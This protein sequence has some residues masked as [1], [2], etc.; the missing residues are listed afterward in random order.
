MR[1]I[2]FLDFDGVLHADG[3]AQLSRLALFEAR[4]RLMPALEIVISSSWREHYS[5][6]S[7]R[8]FFHPDLRHRIIGLTPLL[9]CRYAPSGRQLEIEAYLHAECLNES[10]CRWLALDDMAEMFQGDCKYLLLVDSTQGFCDSV[11]SR[12]ECW[13]RDSSD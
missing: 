11:A 7:F 1:K 10:N 8:N 3:E 9:H 2:V 6:E 5:L 12:L 4:L 13:Y